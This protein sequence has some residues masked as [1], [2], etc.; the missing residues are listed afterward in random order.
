MPGMAF[1]FDFRKRFRVLRIY[2]FG[3]VLP[4]EATAQARKGRRRKRRDR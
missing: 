2:L 1:Y 3:Q 4:K